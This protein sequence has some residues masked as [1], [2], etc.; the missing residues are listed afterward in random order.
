MHS[1]VILF[2]LF[3]LLPALLVIAFAHRMIACSARRYPRLYGR[4]VRVLA[5]LGIYVG[6][7]WWI[8]EGLRFVGGR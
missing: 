8:V 7:T 5:L 6:A 4:V 1:P 2:L 3:F